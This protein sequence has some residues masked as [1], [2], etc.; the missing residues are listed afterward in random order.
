VTGLGQ[1]ITVSNVIAAIA[2]L[3]TILTIVWKRG[4]IR[5]SV[6]EKLRSLRR[7]IETIVQDIRDLRKVQADDRERIFATIEANRAG[8]TKVIQN[9]ETRIVNEIRNIELGQQERH[10]RIRLDVT[11]MDRRTIFLLATCPACP[12]EEV[13][14][15]I[16][17]GDDE[18]HSKEMI[19]T[20]LERRRE[21]EAAGG[22]PSGGCKI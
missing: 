2:V 9:V 14:A 6:F 7:K 1:Y 22:E 10:D 13:A 20:I 12:V 8:V 17:N 5:G 21:E 3:T 4:A 19:E 11:R 16:A 15:F 18:V